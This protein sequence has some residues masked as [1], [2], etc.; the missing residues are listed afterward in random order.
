MAE[1]LSAVKSIYQEILGTVSARISH[2]FAS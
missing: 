1:N 2:E